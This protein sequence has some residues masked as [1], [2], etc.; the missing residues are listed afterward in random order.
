[1]KVTFETNQY[2][3]THGKL[4]RGTGWWVFEVVA[5][6]PE[7][8]RLMIA[9]PNGLVQVQPTG[10]PGCGTGTVLLQVKR[11]TRFSDAKAMVKLFLRGHFRNV[12]VQVC[13]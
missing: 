9:A 8:Y 10:S 2:E 13:S 1:M 6:S 4:P 7:Q 3:F 5:T 11:H 12:N